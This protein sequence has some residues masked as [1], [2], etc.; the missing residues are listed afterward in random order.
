M[1]NF[2]LQISLFIILIANTHAQDTFNFSGYI[3]D[4]PYFSKANQSNS[5][6]SNSK[7]EQFFNLTRLRLR[8]TINLWTNARISLEYEISSLYLSSP[9]FLNQPADKTNKQIVYLTWNMINNPNYLITHFIDRFYFKQ[10]FDIGSLIIGRQRISWGTGRIWNPTD[11]FNPINPTNFGK[12]EKDG[13]DA[14]SLILNLARFT[15]LSFVLNPQE[16]IKNSNAAFR[17]RTNY[18][19]YDISLIGGSFDNRIIIGSDFAGNFFNAGLRG[20]GILSTEKE[21]FRSNFVKY[22]LGLDYQFT[23]KLYGLVEYQYN[24]EGRLNKSEYEIKRLMTGEILNLNKNYLYLMASYL[25]HPLINLNISYNSNLNDGSGFFG[26]IA[27]YSAGDNT[28]ISL[29]TQFFYGKDLDEYSFYPNSVFLKA[30]F[31]F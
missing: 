25:I 2:F 3:I 24:G 8:P 19:E 17:F 5:L 4:I 22:I 14:I 21:N 10:G 18:S 28:S 9:T 20:E 27:G 29:G 31:Y 12:I 11:L 26:F 15:D 16:K 30:E 23:S 7:T 6:L 1:R 13:A